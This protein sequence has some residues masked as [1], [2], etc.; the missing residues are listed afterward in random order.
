[1]DDVEPILFAREDGVVSSL[2][3]EKAH[4]DEE[5]KK[6]QFV[7]KAEKVEPPKTKKKNKR[8]KKK[9]HL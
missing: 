4:S 9:P 2:S 1:M 6:K 3:H 7:A 8:N 5:G